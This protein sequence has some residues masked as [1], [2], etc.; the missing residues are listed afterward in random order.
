MKFQSPWLE[1]A[2]QDSYVQIDVGNNYGAPTASVLVVSAPATEGKAAYPDH[3]WQLIAASCSCMPALP[4]GVT[5]FSLKGRGAAGQA[6]LDATRNGVPPAW[7]RGFSLPG[8]HGR[9]RALR[10]VDDDY[11]ALL[12][13]AVGQGVALFKAAQGAHR[14]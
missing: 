14:S 3:L 2:T 5:D 1:D 6:G 8:W 10:H 11:G 7:S 12:P 13:A 9:G 4:A